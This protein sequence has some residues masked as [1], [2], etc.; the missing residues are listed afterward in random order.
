MECTNSNCCPATCRDSHSSF[1]A[2][3]MLIVFSLCCPCTKNWY[4]LMR[5]NKEIHTINPTSMVAKC[6]VKLGRR[7]APVC[8]TAS[9]PRTQNNQ[10]W[11]NSGDR[12]DFFGMWEGRIFV[13]PS[14][15]KTSLLHYF[16]WAEA[17]K[18]IGDPHMPRQTDPHPQVA[19][20]LTGE[21]YSHC[22]TPT[23]FCGRPPHFCGKPPHHEKWDI[24]TI[25]GR[26]RLK[27][28]LV[29]LMCPGKQIHPPTLLRNSLGRIWK[30][31]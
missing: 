2:V 8:L 7:G 21:T 13:F 22:H 27:K 16:G 28:K 31:W 4:T 19:G 26:L 12:G 29:T 5:P 9:N 11:G 14:N 1:I 6:L 17:E 24:S 10:I 25:L 15:R 23:F 3:T 20:E 18:K 30:S